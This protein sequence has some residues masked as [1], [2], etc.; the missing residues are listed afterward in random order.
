MSISPECL[1]NYFTGRRLITKVKV[2]RWISLVMFQEKSICKETIR[3]CLYMYPP[4]SCMNTWHHVG[5]VLRKRRYQIQFT[6]RVFGITFM[7]YP[8]HR[9]INKLFDNAQLRIKLY[10]PQS[11]QTQ[12]IMPKYCWNN[13]RISGRMTVIPTR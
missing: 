6:Q 9:K 5:M 11:E 3:V 4:R 13:K 7:G 12:S 1:V 2:D 10:R 8:Q